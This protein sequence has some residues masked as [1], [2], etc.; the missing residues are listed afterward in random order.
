MC[1]TPSFLVFFSKQGWRKLSCRHSDQICSEMAEGREDG[2]YLQIFNIYILQQLF[3]GSFPWVVQ[4]TTV[5]FLL[6]K[7]FNEGF[8]FLLNLTHFFEI[9]SQLHPSASNEVDLLLRVLTKVL[10]DL[11]YV[12]LQTTH[13]IVG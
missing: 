2:S 12:L 4:N 7:S 9:L 5:L 8:K 11:L 13:L 3:V 1:P 10:Q 6:V